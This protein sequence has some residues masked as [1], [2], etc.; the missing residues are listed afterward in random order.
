MAF[1]F[2]EAEATQDF[3]ALSLFMPKPKTIGL[4]LEKKQTS[5]HSLC[6]IVLHNNLIK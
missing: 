4:N 2:V 3:L 6:E 1:V 5:V